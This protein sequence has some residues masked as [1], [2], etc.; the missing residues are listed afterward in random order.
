MVEKYSK[1]H[2]FINNTYLLNMSLNFNSTLNCGACLLLGTIR[3]KLSYY[4]D[5]F[6]FGVLPQKMKE[7][8]WFAAYEMYHQED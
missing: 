5:N 7:L 3:S 8:Y 4:I 2:N 6:L 1:E